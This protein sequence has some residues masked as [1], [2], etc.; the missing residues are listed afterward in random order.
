VEE[1]SRWSEGGFEARFVVARADGRPCNPRARY[2]VLDLGLAD[3]GS[4]LDPHAHVAAEAYADSV[5]AHNAE[6]SADL[7]RMLGPA[8][9]PPESAQHKD[10]K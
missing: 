7:K 1:R 3:D 10:A 2:F 8:G 9:W 6:L 4:P 5:A